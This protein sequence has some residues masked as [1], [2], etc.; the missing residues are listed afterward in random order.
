[1][2][3]IAPRTPPAA[4]VAGSGQDP[5]V[6]ASPRLVE[7]VREQREG[8][9]L[10]LDVGQHRVDQAGLESKPGRAGGALD[11]PAKLVGPHRAEQVLVLGQRGGEARMVGASSVEVRPEG[12]H[13]RGG[14]RLPQ[15]HQGVDEAGSARL[16]RTEREHL[17]ELIDDQE[18]GRAG[19]ERTLQ[20]RGRIR[21]GRHHH[22]GPFA[23]SAERRNE[24][25]TDEGRLPA[26][27]RPDHGHEAAVEEPVDGWRPRPPRA[28]RT[29]HRPPIGRPSARGRGR[30]RRVA[31][32]TDRARRAPT[33]ACPSAM[34]FRAARRDRS[35]AEA[36]RR[37][38]RRSDRRSRPV[39]VG[40]PQEPG[41]PGCRLS[42]VAP[43]PG[44]RLPGDCG[45]PRVESACEL[46]G[47]VEAILRRRERHRQRPVVD[48]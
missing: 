28:R 34:P 37:S 42:P 7:G 23:R 44:L 31:G 8:A 40:H 10:A 47:G 26:P 38:P 5:T 15:V 30:C 27:R 2:C 33:P 11:R 14:A 35:P 46:A 43:R 48:G 3:A 36:D 32:S 16:V 45:H 29:G 1:M 18:R 17:L 20:L 22:D 19:G 21:A 13:D 4:T 41:R 6:A 9:G 39:P 25:G 24:P 12:D